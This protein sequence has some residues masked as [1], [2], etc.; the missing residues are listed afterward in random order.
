MISFIFTDFQNR[1]KINEFK[2]EYA[3]LIKLNR[4]DNEKRK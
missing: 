3:I 4:N 2:N 1:R